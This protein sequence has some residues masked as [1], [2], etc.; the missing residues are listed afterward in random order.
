MTHWARYLNYGLLVWSGAALGGG[1]FARLADSPTLGAWLWIAAIAVMVAAVAW[2][3]GRDLLRRAGGVDVLALAALLGSL[4]L[5]EYLA[6]AVIALMF[7]SGRALED[8]AGQRARRSLS[9]LLTRAPQ[10]A[11]RYRGEALEQVPVAE[12]EPGDRLLVRPGDMVPVD[13]IVRGEYAVLDESALTGESAPVERR[14]GDAVG[15][16]VINA[17]SPFDIVAVATAAESTYTGII[18]LVEEAQRSRSPFTRLADR[19]A[20]WFVPLSLGIAGAAWLFSGDPVR[21][22]AVVVVATPCPLLLAA[23]VAVVSGIS[24]AARRGILIKNG[25]ALEALAAVRVVLFDKTGTLTT[26]MAR[27]T[28]I[29]SRGEIGPDEVLRFAASLEQASQHVSAEAIVGEARRRG[30]SLSLPERVHE[31][32]GQGMQGEV[33]G[34]RV[35]VGSHGWIAGEIADTGWLRQVSRRASYEGASPV[36]VLLDERPVGALLLADRIRTE[37]PRVLRALHRAGIGR[38]IMVSGDRQDVAETIATALGVDTVL[39]ER[40]PA[41]KVAAVQAERAE[42]V[43]MMVGDG[44]NDAPALAAAHVGVAMGARGAGASSEAA[45]VV[46]LVDRLDRL[47][48]ALLTARRSRSIARQSVM[49][50]MALSLTAMAVAAVGYLP[51]V[52]GALVQEIIDVAVILNALRALAPATGLRERARLDPETARRL[53]AEHDALA[54]LID[55]LEESA[56]GL[57]RLEPV[58]AARELQGVRRMLRDELMPHEREDEK[59]LYPRMAELL[60]GS[61]P[62]AAMSRTHREIFHLEGLFARIVNDMPEQGP[63]TQQLAELRRLL[64]SLAAILRLHF[65]QE[66]ELFET[67]ADEPLGHDGA[68]KAA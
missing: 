23:P 51:P 41:D 42:A 18:R 34:H 48:E 38:T 7:A 61:D 8:Y 32:P 9:A 53:K 62:L 6:G 46:L 49:A 54:P 66:E 5:G 45:G 17:G 3:I 63:E 52:S 28:G 33:D 47:V 10:Q 57:A 64:Y 29:E 20:L 56:A 12:V 2:E 1:L 15:S 43:T 11:W 58:A 44:I 65:A 24:R 59:Q 37:S 55:R 50:G 21:A 4:A 16:G 35:V 31:R 27:L 30:L 40:S 68:S 14:A 25:A 60:P 39:A 67:L 22:L 19:Y 13:G 36:F 26:G